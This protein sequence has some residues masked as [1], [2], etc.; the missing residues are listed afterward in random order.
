MRM[1]GCLVL[2]WSYCKAGEDVGSC[3]HA[4]TNHAVD[5]AEKGAVTV[6]LEMK[7]Q[8]MHIVIDQLS[9]GGH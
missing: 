7:S 4:N 8:F 5:P 3:S 9:T 1:A 2:V 6:G